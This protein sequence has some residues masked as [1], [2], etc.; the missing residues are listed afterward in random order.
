[1]ILKGN[2]QATDEEKDDSEIKKLTEEINSF[3]EVE[4]EELRIKNRVMR[5]IIV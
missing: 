3:H 5:K 4:V 2:Q 1:M